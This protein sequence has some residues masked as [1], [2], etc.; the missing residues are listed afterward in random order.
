VSGAFRRQCDVGWSGWSVWVLQLR[1]FAVGASER[2][3][4]FVRNRGVQRQL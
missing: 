3:A 2:R 4:L 1:T